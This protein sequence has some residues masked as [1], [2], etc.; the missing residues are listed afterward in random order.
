[1]ERG[2]HTWDVGQEWTVQ[3]GVHE[4]TSSVMK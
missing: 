2:A 3:T 1:M 4:N